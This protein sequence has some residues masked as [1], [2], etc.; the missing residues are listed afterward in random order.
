ML[1]LNDEEGLENAGTQVAG[2]TRS[3]IVNLFHLEPLRYDRLDHAP[4]AIAWGHA[5]CNTKLGQ[6]RCYSVAELTRDGEKV[7]LVREEG[8]ETIGWMSPNFEMMRSP[9]GAV[10]IRICSDRGP[11][12][13]DPGAVPDP[14]LNQ[15]VI[16]S[17]E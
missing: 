13:E 10:W 9:K 2:A 15:A 11:A 5:T 17:S 14:L 4:S 16:Q 1:T 8:I 7:G 3:T 6:R 12:Q